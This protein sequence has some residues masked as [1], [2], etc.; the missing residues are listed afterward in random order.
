V[1]F[2]GATFAFEFSN[3]DF[4]D[5]FTDWRYYAVGGAST[6]FTIVN[7]AYTG[8]NAASMETTA[9]AGGDT[10]LDRDTNRIPVS[11]G[12][13]VNLSF[14]AKKISTG[15]TRIMISV[16]EFSSTGSFLG[17]E[18]NYYSEPVNGSYTEYSFVKFIYNSTTAYINIAFRIV[19]EFGLTTVGHYYIDTVSIV[20]GQMLYNGGFEDGSNGWRAYA[21]GGGSGNFGISSD[22]YEGNNAF[23]FEITAGGGDHGLD[24]WESKI[25]AVAGDVFGVSVATKKL[26]VGNTTLRMYGGEP[27][28]L[29]SFQSLN[30]Q[31]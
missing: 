4:E 17:L 2:V 20:E 26:S 3:G 12:D 16:S 11:K 6:T 21:V 18:D 24:R 29:R 7:D 8:S 9:F 25:P 31:A 30:E 27:D 14:A 19:D 28:L 23:S 15:S 10:A 5:N 1:L 13:V 22:S